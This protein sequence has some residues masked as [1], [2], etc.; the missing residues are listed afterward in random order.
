ML[1]VSFSERYFSY[2]HS[3]WCPAQACGVYK[4]WHILWT[5]VYNSVKTSFLFEYKKSALLIDFIFYFSV[6]CPKTWLAHAFP[7][8]ILKFLFLLRKVLKIQSLNKT[9]LSTFHFQ[10]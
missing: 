2:E 3:G 5:C 10:H 7:K 1:F 8:S 9:T 6:I 4:L